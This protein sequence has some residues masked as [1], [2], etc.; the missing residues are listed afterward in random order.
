MAAY[1]SYMHVINVMN[2]T[3]SSLC[4][5]LYLGYS[6]NRKTSKAQCVISTTQRKNLLP[7]FNLIENGSWYSLQLFSVKKRNINISS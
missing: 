5:S 6:R 3:E 1:I 4:M 2:V 7:S